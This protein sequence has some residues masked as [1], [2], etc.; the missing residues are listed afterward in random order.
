[1]PTKR[2]R[3][4]NGYWRGDGHA[5]QYPE[6]L[7]HLYNLS[8]IGGTRWPKV[9]WKLSKKKCPQQHRVA[10][11]IFDERGRMRPQFAWTFPPHRISAPSTIL[12]AKWILSGTKSILARFVHDAV[13]LHQEG[14]VLPHLVFLPKP[15]PHD[16][17]GGLTKE[18]INPSKAMKLFLDAK[19][20]V[21]MADATL[22]ATVEHAQEK[23]QKFRVTQ[24]PGT[25]GKSQSHMTLDYPDIALGDLDEDELKIFSAFPSFMDGSS[26]SLNLPRSSTI[27]DLIFI[28][29][30]G[31]HSNDLSEAARVRTGRD[32]PFGV[33]IPP[34]N[35]KGGW[36]EHY[37][38]PSELTAEHIAKYRQWLVTGGEEV[39]S[40]NPVSHMKI[41]DIARYRVP[42]SGNDTLPG[43]NSNN[44]GP[45][46]RIFFQK[47]FERVERNPQKSDV[48]AE[49]LG[50][51]DASRELFGEH[52]IVESLPSI[53][54]DDV[55]QAKEIYLVNVP[56]CVLKPL[57]EY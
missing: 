39:P 15:D 42:R 5:D 2:C 27:A 40:N 16:D 29:R 8:G 33:I 26:L 38:G 46:D 48:L 47:E 44:S 10:P 13:V 25:I 30:R 22:S 7:P 6:D 19:N 24:L 14:S 43:N 49:R 12:E 41:P 1:M 57:M 35:D 18:L 31:R 54:T 37:Y 20:A 34:F 23:R 36:N 3:F 4:P 52:R 28:F 9:S 51:E 17:M 50:L 21:H 11:L 53:D 32:C 56:W 55:K 45:Q